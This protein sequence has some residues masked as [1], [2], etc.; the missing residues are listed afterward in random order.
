MSAKRHR[1]SNANGMKSGPAH[2]KRRVASCC[3]KLTAPSPPTIS[4]P[5]ISFN[6]TFPADSLEFCPI[7]G[8]QSVFVCGTYKLEDQPAQS[9]VERPIEPD[10]SGVQTKLSQKRNGQCLT[11]KLSGSGLNPSL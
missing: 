1:H 8:F 6:T 9:T 10:E 11:F 7:N 3:H 5:M 2:Q 4:L